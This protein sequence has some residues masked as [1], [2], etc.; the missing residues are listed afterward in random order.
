MT[1]R[2]ILGQHPW[3]PTGLFV[4]KPGVSVGSTNPADRTN[5]SFSTEWGQVATIIAQGTVSP[6]TVVTMPS[7]TDYWPAVWW[8]PVSGNTL[9]P[10]AWWQTASSSGSTQRAFGTIYQLTYLGGNPC[11]IRWDDLAPGGVDRAGF[12]DIKYV[13]FGLRVN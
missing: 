8:C 10:G 4:S 6:G 5:L 1:D 12:F 9:Q 2:V 13:A 3:G 11:Q 7:G